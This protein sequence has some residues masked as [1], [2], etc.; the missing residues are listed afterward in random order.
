MRVAQSNDN[1][2]GVVCAA[3]YGGCKDSMACLCLDF[4]LGLVRKRYMARMWDGVQARERSPSVLFSSSQA[5]RS[6]M[7][8]V[9]L[10]VPVEC[11]RKSGG[12]D[13]DGWDGAEKKT[14]RRAKRK[15]KKNK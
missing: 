1:S 9:R 6:E 12:S 4:T 13:V 8:S 2:V 5:A 15:K 3:S 11:P 10:G 14:K 7:G